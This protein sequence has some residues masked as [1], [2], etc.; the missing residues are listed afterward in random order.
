[1]RF[2]MN[3]DLVCSGLISNKITNKNLMCQTNMYITSDQPLSHMLS[4]KLST[5]FQLEYNC[6]RKL[7]SSK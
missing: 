4:L 3:V 5:V 2:Q 7:R 6:M 1:M